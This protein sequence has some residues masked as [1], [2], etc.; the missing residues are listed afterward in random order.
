MVIGAG[1]VGDEAVGA[2]V[3]GERCGDGGVEWRRLLVMARG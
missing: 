3:G 1:N 2:G